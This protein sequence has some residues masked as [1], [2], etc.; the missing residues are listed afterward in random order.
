M[1]LERE[2]G[3]RRRERV[4]GYIGGAQARPIEVIQSYPASFEQLPTTLVAPAN[5]HRTSCPL[6]H[7]SI[8]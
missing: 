3:R 2:E 1:M 4:I 5:A 6:D 8:T 7:A